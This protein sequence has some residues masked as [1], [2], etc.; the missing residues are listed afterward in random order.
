MTAREEFNAALKAAAA[1][2]CERRSLRS[3]FARLRDLDGLR[4]PHGYV[5]HIDDGT[6]P[7]AIIAYLV[8][9]GTDL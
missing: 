3:K 6:E 1:A 9:E 2:A 8:K 7:D 5:L 4:L